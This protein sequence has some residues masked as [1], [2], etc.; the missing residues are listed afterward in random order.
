M[1]LAPRLMAGARRGVR[2]R[3]KSDPIDKLA[4]A[5]AALREGLESLPTAR[6]AGPEHE[7]RMLATYRERLLDMRTR[8]SNELRGQLHDLWPGGIADCGTRGRDCWSRSSGP[9]AEVAG[10]WPQSR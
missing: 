1:R 7:I 6:L 2:T 4:I 8:L 5:R 9:R 3:G 10:R